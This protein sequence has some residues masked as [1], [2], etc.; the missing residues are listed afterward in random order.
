MP[1]HARMSM[2]ALMRGGVGFQ[3]LRVPVGVYPARPGTQLIIRL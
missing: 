3:R 2:T 1:E